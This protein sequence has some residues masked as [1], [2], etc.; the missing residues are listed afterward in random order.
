MHAD[1]QLTAKAAIRLVPAGETLGIAE[2]IETALSASALF[3]VPCWAAMS[4][5]MLAAWEPPPEARRIIIFGDND[6]N[7][8]GQASEYALARRLRSDERVVEVQIPAEAGSD[9]NDVHQLQL[10]LTELGAGHG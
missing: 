6:A 5:G 8:V 9:W 10:N 4:A 3:G 7:Y 1:S 2:G